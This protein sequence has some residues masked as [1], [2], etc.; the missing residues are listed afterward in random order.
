M[1]E[2][3]RY[4]IRISAFVLKE[5]F[6]IL[7]QPLL[8]MTLVL[9][10]F[11]I[12]FFFGIGYRNEAR[13]LKTLFYVKEDNVLSDKLDQYTGSLGPQLDSKGKTDNL[14]EAK[15]HLRQGDIDLITVL[16]TGAYDTIRNNEQAVFKLP[17]YVL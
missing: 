6:E 12:L 16:P 17:N 2:Y 1:N 13:A 14:D 3:S 7:R 10:P 11:L 9:G 8:L 15:E 4:F 5:I